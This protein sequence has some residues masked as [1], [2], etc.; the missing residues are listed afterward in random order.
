MPDQDDPEI[1]MEQGPDSGPP[2]RETPA[3]GASPTRGSDADRR[4]AGPGVPLP[5][6]PDAPPPRPPV[7]A[8]GPATVPGSGSNDLSILV[9]ALSK[10]KDCSG[11]VRACHAAGG[12]TERAFYCFYAACC[13]NDVNEARRLLPGT[14]IDSQKHL[15]TDCKQMGNPDVGLRALDCEHNVRDCKN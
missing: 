5:R 13:Q 3:P 15:R 8:A 6:S 14:P 12:R 11:V 4:D 7:H 10:P 1:I 2:D 9:K